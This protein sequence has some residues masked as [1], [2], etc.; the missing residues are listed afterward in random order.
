MAETSGMALRMWLLTTLGDLGGAGLRREVHERL[1]LLFAHDFTAEDKAPRVGRGG[2]AAWRNN[3]DSLYHRMKGEKLPLVAAAVRNDPWA[4]L[5]AGWSE[6]AGEGDHLR[7]REGLYRQF[8]PKNSGTYTSYTPART[9]LKSRK[10]EAVLEQYGIAMDASG[11]QLNTNVHPRDLEL[12]REAILCLAEVKMVYDGNAVQ[13]CRSAVAQL[14]E[15]R[16]FYYRGSNPVCLAVFSE[17][18]GDALVEFLS[19]LGIAAVWQVD[20]GWSGSDLASL[21]GLVPTQLV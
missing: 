11:W 5:P 20:D 17:S 16:H 15:Y 1:A 7:A 10:H 18:I 8:K 19:S 12:D 4:L 6:L 21:R 14:L 3:V 9:Q 13:A 2:E